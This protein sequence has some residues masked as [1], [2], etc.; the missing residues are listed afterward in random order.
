MSV[1]HATEQGIATPRSA[2]LAM[3]RGMQGEHDDK[4]TG[5]VGCDHACATRIQPNRLAHTLIAIPLTQ[6]KC[7]AFLQV[8]FG[9]SIT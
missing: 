2:R 6:G 4:I 5:V 9:H 3:K 7:Y 8:R 1:I